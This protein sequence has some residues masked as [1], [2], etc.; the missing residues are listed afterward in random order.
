MGY[1]PSL[2]GANIKQLR[3]DLYKFV[4]PCSKKKPKLGNACSQF[5]S[6][7]MSLEKITGLTLQGTFC[8]VVCRKLIVPV[9]GNIPLWLPSSEDEI[10]N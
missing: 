1:F 9:I 8:I 7:Q 10:K 4:R 5:P 6:K 2:S 3:F